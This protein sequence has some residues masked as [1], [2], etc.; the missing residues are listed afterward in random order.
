MLNKQERKTLEDEYKFAVETRKVSAKD[1]QTYHF[2]HGYEV[3][4]REAM[5]KLGYTFNELED[6]VNSI[7][8]YKGDI[9]NG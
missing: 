7:S 2:N 9:N 3:G 8:W 4:L 5:S 1:T 6:I